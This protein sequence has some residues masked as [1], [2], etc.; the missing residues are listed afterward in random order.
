MNLAFTS[1]DVVYIS[2][3]RGA[4]EDVPNLRYTNEVIGAYVI[5]GARIHLYSYLDLLGENV[6]YCDADSVICIQASDDPPLNETGDK[7]EDITSDLRS[8]KTITEFVSGGPKNYAYREFDT[9]VGRE[10]SVCKIRG[11]TLKYNASKMVNFDVIRGMI[12][13]D[14]APV[15]NVHTE[16]M[17]KRKRNGG[18]TVAIV[19]EPENKIYRISVFKRRR[20]G[21][22][23]SV[24]FGNK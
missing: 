3:K 8:S 10:K 13:G 14:E 7:L 17:I 15:I 11:I 2:W 22:N 5:G 4:E 1:D 9:G 12:V 24:P 6:M 16:N 21:D 18:G 20:L 23:T 19:T